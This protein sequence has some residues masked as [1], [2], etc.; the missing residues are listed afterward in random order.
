MDAASRKQLR[1]RTQRNRK[2]LIAIVAVLTFPVSVSYLAIKA[3][4]RNRDK[5]RRPQ[6][7]TQP[8]TS[9]KRGQPGISS[10]RRFYD[11]RTKLWSG[12]GNITSVELEKFLL[13]EDETSPFR[14]SAGYE[15]ARWHAA[16]GETSAAL[17]AMEAAL[18][19]NS[20]VVKAKRPRIIYADLL[21]RSGRLDAAATLLDE[22]VDD[23]LVPHMT[24]AKSNLL[25]ARSGGGADSERLDLLNTLYRANGLVELGFR[26][27]DR[28]FHIA[29]LAIPRA[30][31]SVEG[32]K[33]SVLMPVYN[34]AAELDF[35][36]R[37]ILGQSWTNIELV[38][39]DDAS[40]DNTWEIVQRHAAADGRIRATRNEAN[41]GAYVT[42]NRA[43]RL[44]RG[45]LVTVHDS[46]D[47]SHPEL[48]ATQTR[49][50]LGDET[51]RGV[52]AH[53]ARVTEDMYYMILPTRPN[54][55][56]IRVSYPSF[57]MRRDMLLSL[58]GWDDVT[59]NGD[60]ELVQRVR[61][62]HGRQAVKPVDVV[63]PLTFQLC[64]ENSLTHSATTSLASVNFGVRRSYALQAGHWHQKQIAADAPLIM[65]RR[66]VKQPFP[67]P[68]IIAPKTWPRN[69][70]YDLVFVSD[71]TL[72]GGTRRCNQ[73][74]LSVA[75]EMGLRVGLYHYPR[76]DLRLKDI[77]P[78]Y[79]DLTANDG[80]DLLVPEDKVTTRLCI[81]HHPPILRY[82]IDA[83]PEI[84]CDHLTVLV[85][86]SPMQLWSEA[87]HLYDPTA[88]KAACRAM[89]GREPTWT[90]ISPRV[91]RILD[92]L[93]GYDPINPEIWYP[94]L[95]TGI[96]ASP[97]SLA[98][99]PGRKIVIGRHSRD[100]WTKWPETVD[101]I[102][103]AY[104]V[105]RGDIE[106]RFLGGAGRAL[107]LLG[108]KPRN[109]QVHAFDTLD[110]E[111]FLES[112]DFF[113]NFLHPD[114][115]E[116]FG[117]NTMEAMARGVVVIIDPEQ[118]EIF[119]DAALY[120]APEGVADLIHEFANDVGK[121]RE[122]ARRGFDFLDRNC[123]PERVGRNL[124]RF[125]SAPSRAG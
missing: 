5:A 118:R 39:V 76:W 105:N 50:F 20:K 4:R 18:R 125:L 45:D 56:A 22:P 14:V 33:V 85:N 34:A 87:P 10:E 24:V 65:D 121:Y 84:A 114:Y 13:K 68:Q 103:T 93:G 9:G 110:V 27:A 88:V 69:C 54:P 86:Q 23:T 123:S 11:L 28:G 35:A 52:F 90:A 51:L 96:S 57:M 1:K 6:D 42:R 61:A 71:L 70:D 2:I 107:E 21:V 95:D 119:G 66:S 78:D 104:C 124:E 55:D 38:I 81:V 112:L 63:A 43:L 116:E 101:K 37:S 80:I 32:P 3:I 41:L 79:L 53:S 17:K 44:A 36:L 73:G 122:Q 7:V 58:G 12:F 75:M 72:L 117:R 40:T 15:L 91:V 30:P 25:H 60:D 8:R 77:S 120:S 115:I 89:F 29:N 26:D 100:H 67:I 46:D 62:V 82:P 31:A 111:E 94:P 59:V 113:V 74:Y 49:H 98:S 64:R 16:K 102:A 106:V 19:C 99:L 47:W 97:K 83:V 109:W 92:S 48:I 108:K